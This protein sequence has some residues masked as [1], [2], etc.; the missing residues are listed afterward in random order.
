M[1]ILRFSYLRMNGF[2]T[3]EVEIGRLPSYYP[4]WF[5][6]Q[7]NDVVEGQ[8]CCNPSLGLV[9]KARACKRAGQE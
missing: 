1:K 6:F 3:F 4:C 7:N 5:L 8:G 2:D 9:A